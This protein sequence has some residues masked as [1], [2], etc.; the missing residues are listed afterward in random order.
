MQ[1]EF[2]KMVQFSLLVKAG[3]RLREFN[4]RKLRDPSEERFTV[5]VCD[6]R[7]DRIHFIVQKKEEEW[8]I[9][10]AGLPPWIAQNE[11][12][13]RQAIEEELRHW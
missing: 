6:E 4:F 13:L 2:S 1:L 9:T 3:E 5:N 8:K 12:K 11:N 7:G 10:T